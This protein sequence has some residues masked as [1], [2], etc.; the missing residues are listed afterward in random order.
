MGFSFSMYF[1]L[2]TKAVFH[3]F[4]AGSYYLLG[5][6]K[7]GRKGHFSILPVKKSQD[8]DEKASGQ[9]QKK[10]ITYQD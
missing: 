9:V 4:H 2:Y 10:V 8:L 6:I 5:S 7:P 1:L 3:S